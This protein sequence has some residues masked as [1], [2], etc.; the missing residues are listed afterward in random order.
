MNSEKKKRIREIIFHYLGNRYDRE[1]EVKLQQWLTEDRDKEEKQECSLEYWDSI[2]A[3]PNSNTY[4]KL[5]SIC[6]NT[7]ISVDNTS[8]YRRI[9]WSRVAAIL[10][11]FLIILGG[12]M[13]YKQAIVMPYTIVHVSYGEIK[14]ITLGDGSEVLLNAGTTFK[15]PK[16]FDEKTRTVYLEGEAFFSIHKNEANPFVVKT[17]T[18]SVKV[19]GTQFNVKAYTDEEKITTTL[20]SGK[21]EVE[22]KAG[23]SNILMPNQ[24][25]TYDNQ[26]AGVQIADIAPEDAMGWTKGDLIFVDNTL[27]EIMQILERR[28]NISIEADRKLLMEKQ[29]YTVKFLQNESIEQL[30][31]ILED[32][33]GIFTYKTNGNKLILKHK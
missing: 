29:I 14:E 22:T 32:L 24:Q 10:L 28:F 18:I 16:T 15:Y 7:G 6:R 1:T 4:R 11:P 13:Y 17:H 21:V 23:K 9:G 20:R 25:L 3:K 30:M 31:T 12:Y 26:T 33:T 27:K 2:Q 8:V 5:K 19:L